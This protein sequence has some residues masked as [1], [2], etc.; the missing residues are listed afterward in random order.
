MCAGCGIGL[1][2]GGASA[3]PA[4]MISN[5]SSVHRPFTPLPVLPEHAPEHYEG[6]S[7]DGCTSACSAFDRLFGLVPL[8][9]PGPGGLNG[10][11]F[12]PAHWALIPGPMLASIGRPRPIGSMSY[13]PAAAITRTMITTPYRIAARACRRCSEYRASASCRASRPRLPRRS[14]CRSPSPAR[15]RAISG[16]PG[17]TGLWEDMPVRFGRGSGAETR[18]ITGAGREGRGDGAHSPA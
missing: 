4:L 13:P 1:G 7:H 15:P 11:E 8:L 16:L 10:P 3:A 14:G 2:S 5:V 9:P 12:Q 17:A 6:I 18:T